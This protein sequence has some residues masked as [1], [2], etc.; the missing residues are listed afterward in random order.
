M[1]NMS[2]I[3]N[4]TAN[5]GVDTGAASEGATGSIVGSENKYQYNTTFLATW[6]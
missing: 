5:S 6:H 1:R 4:D 3:A 2:V